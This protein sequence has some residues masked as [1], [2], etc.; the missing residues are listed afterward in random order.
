[1]IKSDKLGEVRPDAVYKDGKSIIT[2]SSIKS[3]LQAETK[4]YQIP[5]A[6]TDDQI[7]AG[8]IFDSTT[9]DC[10]VMYHPEH[11]SDYL[12][13][14]ISI[15][16]Q[17]IM[18]YVVV[19]TFGRSSQEG[20]ARVAKMASAEL[21]QGNI[22]TALFA[23]ALSLGKNKKKLEDESNYYDTIEHILDEVLS[24]ELLAKIEQS[25][26][27]TS[28][29]GDRKDTISSNQESKY[30]N[31][32]MS[33][34]D[35]TKQSLN[36]LKSDGTDATIAYLDSLINEISDYMEAYMVRGE[37]FK[38]LGRYQEAISDIDKAITINPSNPIS[39]NLRGISCIESG[40]D[41][42]KA[43]DDFN[44]A[45]S[46]DANYVGAYTNRGNVYLKMREFQN[47]VRDCTKAI[48]LSRGSEFV[49]YNNRGL[50][51]FHMKEFAKA[52]NDF[53]NVIKLN[54]ENADAYMR[55]GGCHGEL[56][57]LQGAISDFE[58]FIAIDPDNKNAAL[59]REGINDLKTRIKNGAI[60]ENSSIKIETSKT[61]VDTVTANAK[62]NNDI[63]AE[64]VKQKDEHQP[65]LNYK[66]NEQSQLNKAVSK[67]GKRSEIITTAKNAVEI[68]AVTDI[69]TE[70][71]TVKSE[72]ELKE[73]FQCEAAAK[74]RVLGTLGINLSAVLSS[75]QT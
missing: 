44:K 12:R 70:V 63:S 55:R 35:L 45:I 39:Y 49:P 18:T 38:E 46:I 16:R 75:K 59:V 34:G 3:I 24:V 43:L 32:R 20:K 27:T 69:R 68:K 31:Q 40:G 67:V 6:F 28:S 71:K 10:I 73:Q 61:H 56:G 23:G 1:M 29:N 15:R 25:K 30:T 57:N 37:L 21:R 4:E 74:K 47:A 14:A 53:D 2:L 64:R 41:I 52:L 62:S 17:G 60:E 19:N 54:P 72:I 33:Y 48:E 58:K 50:A 36:V 9:T 65:R 26:D 8:G 13:Y 51:Y 42:N 5:I 7:K 22:G 66:A 11:P